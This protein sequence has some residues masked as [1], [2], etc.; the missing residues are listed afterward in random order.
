MALLRGDRTPE[1]EYRKL[2]QV[3]QWRRM[4]MGRPNSGSVKTSLEKTFH[5]YGPRITASERKEADSVLS[6]VVV[7]VEPPVV[8]LA[9]E[10][11]MRCSELVRRR[12]EHVS[13][14]R[15]VAH[16]PNIKNGEAARSAV[17]STSWQ[18]ATPEPTSDCCWRSCGRAGCHPQGRACA[19]SQ[20]SRFRCPQ[21]IWAFESR[22][23]QA[24]GR[25]L[26]YSI[27]TR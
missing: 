20:R 19:P 25:K 9:L 21:A 8:R 27:P 11:A 18:S 2:W 10:T 24:A 1:R 23:R 22:I 3:N 26:G 12:W 6:G 17:F 4:L 14:D 7:H 15:R 16:L 5:N 13:L